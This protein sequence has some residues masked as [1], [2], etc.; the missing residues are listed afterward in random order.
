VS[1]AAPRITVEVGGRQ[2]SLSNL[3][4]PLWPD[5]TTKADFIAYVSAIAPVLLPHLS[6]RALTVRRFPDGADG[7]TFY[8]KRSPSHRPDWVPTV[9]L[10]VTTGSNR[11]G[12]KPTPGKVPTREEVPFTVVE[13]VATL[14]WLANLACLELHTPMARA[15]GPLGEAVPTLVVLDLDPGPPATSVEC[16]V[17]A[18]RIRDV[19]D[20][21]GLT[22]VVK[23]SGSK[24]I[25]VY[26]PLNVP[27]TTQDGARGFAQAIAL[28]L[29]KRDPSLVVSTQRKDLRGGKVLVDWLQNDP[30]KTTVSVYSTRAKDRPYTSAPLTW[31]EVEA[32]AD[33]GHPSD[34]LF[35]TAAT[36]A[37]VEEHG[38]LFAA[39]ND[40]EQ[41]LPTLY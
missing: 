4:K 15:A 18:L 6:G 12:E 39:A 27:G 23:S 11:W 8:E 20:H 26:I 35:D 16:A 36:L 33:G 32:H 3:D 40:L 34:I 41:E 24:G 30:S 17:V 38:D 22:T 28:L 29:E 25:Q 31:E 7:P 10:W 9:P 1:P 2:L 37:R 5:G 21:L 19:L 13:E 14:V